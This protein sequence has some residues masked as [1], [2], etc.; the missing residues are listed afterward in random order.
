MCVLCV[1]PTGRIVRRQ[2]LWRR[3]ECIRLRAGCGLHCVGR[4][5]YSVAGCCDVGIAVRLAG[6]FPPGA[7]CSACAGWCELYVGVEVRL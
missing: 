7:P 3:C 4:G 6:V 1:G 2:L 5:V